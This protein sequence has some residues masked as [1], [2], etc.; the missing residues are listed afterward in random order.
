[1]APESVAGF[2]VTDKS[3][4]NRSIAGKSETDNTIKT[5]KKSEILLNQSNMFVSTMTKSKPLKKKTKKRPE[6]SQPKKTIEIN[7][8]DLAAKKR[9][10][11]SVKKL[12]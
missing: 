8:T 9:T 4:T 10:K 1:V 12:N 11:Q 3:I 6:T 5:V 2:S 7:E